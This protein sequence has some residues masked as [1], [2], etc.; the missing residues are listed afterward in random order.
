M[1][2]RC[3]SPDELDE[4]EFYFK[5]N[6][7][8]VEPRKLKIFVLYPVVLCFCFILNILWTSYHA[9]I[10]YHCRLVLW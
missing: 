3:V 10:L 9:T 7:N 4:H 1:P 6:L 8:A 5:C 2:I